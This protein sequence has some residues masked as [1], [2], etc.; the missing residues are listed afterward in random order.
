MRRLFFLLSALLIGNLP[1]LMACE[2]CKEPSNVA[3]DS[4]VAGI[5]ASFSWSVVFMLGMLTFLLTGMVLMMVRSCKQLAEQQHPA[6]T[7][8][9]GNFSVGGPSPLGVRS[10]G[11]VLPAIQR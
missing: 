7:P 11:S 6:A 1:S 10:Y 8:E 9:R 3:G 4:G 2:G 5:S